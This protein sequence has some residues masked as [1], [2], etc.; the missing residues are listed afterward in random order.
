M[1][2]AK[3]TTRFLVLRNG[4]VSATIGAAGV[5]PTEVRKRV[6]NALKG[7]VE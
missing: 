6:V 2:L 7:E 1:D 4:V 3:W 5:D